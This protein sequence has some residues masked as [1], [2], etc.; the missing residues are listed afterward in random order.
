MKLE[1]T[2]L[3]DGNKV[4]SLGALNDITYYT[5]IGDS[6]TARLYFVQDMG[7]V[8][9]YLDVEGSTASN[10]RTQIRVEFDRIVSVG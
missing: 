5:T 7:V 4:R 1:K 8:S 2:I 10:D 3:I 6:D 9:H